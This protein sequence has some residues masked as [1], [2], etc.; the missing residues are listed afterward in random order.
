MEDTIVEGFKG[1]RQLP[2]AHWICFILMI[3][4]DMMS[5]ELALAMRDSPIAFHEYDMRQLMGQ[6]RG[7]RDT[8]QPH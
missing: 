4:I 7:N 5:P 3:A 1:H 6:S 2:F 8:R